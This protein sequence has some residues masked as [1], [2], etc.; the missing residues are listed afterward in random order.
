MSVSRVVIINDTSIARGGATEVA[1]AEATAL[2][3]R[4]VAVTLVTGDDGRNPLLTDLGIE[5]VALAERPIL[6][7]ARLEGGL[8][9]LFNRRAAEMLSRWIAKNDTPS[10]VY[11]LHNWS[12]I[13]SPSIFL[14][15]KRVRGRLVMTIHDYFMACPNG[16]YL[17]YRRDTS[18]PLT[19]M[20]VQCLATNCDRR[21]Y[22]HKIWR[23]ARQMSR[24]MIFDV[25]AEHP[26]MLTLHEGMRPYLVRGDLPASAM[27]VLRNPIRPFSPDRIP[28]EQNKEF[29]FV[30]RL[31]REK[32][33]DL[34][35]R[36]ARLAGAT[37]RFIGDGPM[38]A[39]LEKAYPE[40]IFSGWR[41]MEEIEPLVRSARALIMSSRVPEPFGMVAVE[42]LWSGLPVILTKEALLA[43]EIVERGVG[44]SCDVRDPEAFAEQIR[45]LLHDDRLV[46]AMSR[47]A[48]KTT[49]DMGNTADQWAESLTAILNDR[50]EITNPSPPNSAPVAIGRPSAQRIPRSARGSALRNSA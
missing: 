50:V 8:R 2:R 27:R 16:G 48:V 9:G 25:Q 14:P 31:E 36:A 41:S 11:H 32:G 20:S 47:R 23:V 28:A 44:L 42:A 34:A 45:R 21:N 1:L 6:E 49:Q 29:I 18:C 30:G 39:E 13:L 7:I 22:A 38:R 10:T 5:V 17:N 46:A 26:V 3:A 33:P 4:G 15:L 19:P 40:F 37:M 35:A 24:K 12:H 43:E